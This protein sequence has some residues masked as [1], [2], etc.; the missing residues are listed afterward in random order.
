LDQSIVTIILWIILAASIIGITLVIV[1][2][3]K[4]GPGSSMQGRISTFVNP[5]E[6]HSI[7]LSLLGDTT[8]TFV[9]GL[10]KFREWLNS[11]L[12]GL[13]SEK[14]QIKISSAYWPITDTEFIV[15]RILTVLLGVIIG[16]LFTRNILG[17]LFLGILLLFIFPL[18]LERSI[19]NRQTRFHHQL[20]DVLVL[21]KGA[22]QA[23][24]SLPQAL[25]LAL[26]EITPP[27]SEEFG[28]V[29]KEVRIGFPLEQA[30]TNLAER[31][32]NDDLQI[33]VTAIIINS[34]VGGNLSTVLDSTIE[35][36]RD[37]MQLSSEIRSLTAYSRYVGNF[38][39]FL[40][41]IAGGVIFLITP[42]YFQ[43]V[44]NSMLV[45]I[46]F[47]LALV[48]MI[49]GNIWIRRTARVKV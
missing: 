46:I 27:S 7:P 43:T 24:Y 48:S 34:Q 14:L 40:P 4:N 19:I 37:R 10:D 20:M 15:I 47:A 29:L 42:D 21:I 16:W 44:F 31:M 35:T 23:G 12:K 11:K 3:R 1:W 33:V 28:R 9:N 18:I 6:S 17:G 25:D 38:L 22:V 32:E 45:Q 49:I 8:S 36:I 5:D 39:S 26:K 2:L 30:L 13:S 41:F